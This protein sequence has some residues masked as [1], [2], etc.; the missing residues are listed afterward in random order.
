[1]ATNQKLELI[2]QYRDSWMTYV[3]A[4]K[5]ANSAV[6]TPSKSSPTAWAN[7][8]RKFEN[9]FN[10]QM[11]NLG[12][13]LTAIESWDPNATVSPMLSNESWSNTAGWFVD[14]VT[15]QANS[16]TSAAWKVASST[17]V[18]SPTTT[19]TNSW[20]INTSSQWNKSTVAGGTSVNPN[21]SQETNLGR[22][23]KDATNTYVEW[24]G[25]TN[26]TKADSLNTIEGAY[27]EMDRA[28][29]ERQ[30]NLTLESMEESN[31]IQKE[32]E[33]QVKVLQA[34]QD[35]E[36]NESMAN[37]AYVESSNAAAENDTRIANEVALM[38]SG[39]LMAK[40]GLSLSTAGITQAQ[41]IYTQWVYRLA[42]LKT[43]NSYNV[44]KLKNDFA[45]VEF[46]HTTAVNKIITDAE[47]DSFKI[48]QDLS[49]SIYEIKLSMVKNKLEKQESTNKI[50][51][52]YIKAKEDLEKGFMEKLNWVN[53]AL[54][55]K[56]TS[57]YNILKTKETYANTKITTAVTSGTWSTLPLSQR[58]QLEQEAWL[59][60]GTVEKQ[61]NAQIGES[62]FKILWDSGITEG[63]YVKIIQSAR[64][65]M[66]TWISLETAVNRTLLLNPKYKALVAKKNAPKG[67]W[68]GSSSSWKIDRVN[69]VNKQTNEIWT[70]YTV[71]WVIVDSTWAPLD[72]TDYAEAWNLSLSDATVRKPDLIDKAIWAITWK[73]SWLKVNALSTEN[74]NN[75]SPYLAPTK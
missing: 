57:Q 30:M 60:A 39:T 33:E 73:W 69:L 36:K 62:I 5:A 51:D 67:S 1:M 65:L 15:T 16:P 31:R 64:N 23:T 56:V 44:A 12:A 45:K 21:L 3:D 34:R 8:L 6:A 9:T 17:S 13:D 19:T 75:S 68:G 74:A 38:Q 14:Y 41:Q 72:L 43:R 66:E 35:A 32:K 59:P 61:I 10:R 27:S 37:I 63:E 22:V 71:W 11:S 50:M 54:E 40:L 47:K 20:A 25:I 55:E 26:K 2:K 53:K 24:V 52:D 46:D 18:P 70:F 4:A 58:A 7:V 29:G 49:K 48:R 28:M 42:E